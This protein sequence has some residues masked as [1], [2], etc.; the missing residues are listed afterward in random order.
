MMMGQYKYFIFFLFY[1][2]RGK[3]QVHQNRTYVPHWE[4]L[5]CQVIMYIWEMFILLKEAN[6]FL[7]RKDISMYSLKSNI[8]GMMP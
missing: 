2:A 6:S 5:E 3:D 1:I 4:N 7:F 8:T